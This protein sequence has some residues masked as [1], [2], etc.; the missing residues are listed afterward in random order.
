M[1]KYGLWRFGTVALCIV[2]FCSNEPMEIPVISPWSFNVKPMK[3][4]EITP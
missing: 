3:F 1:V 4:H 2:T